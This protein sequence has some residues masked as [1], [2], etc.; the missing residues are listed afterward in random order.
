MEFNAEFFVAVAFVLFLCGMAYLGVHGKIG[1]ALDA[2]VKAIVDELE[3]AKSLRKEAASLLASFEAKRVA[4]EAEA[5]QI[6]AQA[7]TEAEVFAREAEARINEFINRRTAQA[8]AKIA[9]A[10]SQ[11]AHEVRASAADAAVRAAGTVLQAHANGPAGASFIEK[12]IADLKSL[13]N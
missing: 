13:M 2:R 7:K 5:A 3:Q 4:A 8:D 11:A 12:G 9:I 6:V 1:A 10:E